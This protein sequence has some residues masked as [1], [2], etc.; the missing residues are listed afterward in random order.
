MKRDSPK[1]VT[2]R[3]VAQYRGKYRV[4]HK[5][6]E[7]WAE[8]TGKIMYTAES[9]L[10]YPVV[11]D[12]VSIISLGYGNGLIDK[13]L[14]RKSILERRAVGK[15]DVQPIA[16]N[17]DTAFIVQA[18][19]RDFNLNR[20]E[21]YLTIVK[22][23]KIKPVLVLNKIDLIPPEE[24]EDKLSL[25]KSRFKDINL[26][27][28]SAFKPNGDKYLAQAI[29]KGKIYCLLGSS[30][31]GKSSLINKLLGQELIKTRAI[32]A[33]T[34]KGQHVTT[35]RELF[36]LKGGGMVID[37]PG[38]REVGV[39]DAGEAVADVFSDISILARDCKFSDCT[40]DHEI[41]CAVLAALKSGQLSEEQYLNYIKLKKE[42][43]YYAMSK[44]EKRRKDKSFGK[45]VK[46][47]MKQ[48][49][50]LK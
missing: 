48:I 26:L 40:H 33:T 34:K 13:I 7:Y 27:T 35:H 36:V 20:F 46:T 37:N 44:L 9:Q 43:D 49:K 14:P 31:V 22:A 41:G 24:L 19:D 4:L 15:T 45:M 39:A 21:R 16:A 6:E 25:V 18:V 32:S 42:T 8:V 23:G 12:K 3:V 47:A 30:G 10:D 29:K 5:N 50:S 28:T 1:Y 2:A 17:V 11:G 38:M